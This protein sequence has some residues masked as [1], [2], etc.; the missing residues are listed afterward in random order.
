MSTFVDPTS[1]LVEY[2]EIMS[3][4]FA[5][6]AEPYYDKMVSYCQSK[7]WHQLTLLVLE[8]FAAKNTL[9]VVD[10]KDGAASTS[11]TFLGVYNHI[12]LKVAA[13]LNPLA[14][15]RMA[16]EVA[17]LSLDSQ[18]L[19]SGVAESEAAMA[20]SKKLLQDLLP[21]TEQ[22]ATLYLQSK[23]AL[24]QMKGKTT[25]PEELPKIYSTIKSNATL[26]HQLMMPDTPEAILVHS[27]HYQM[28]MTYFKL[29]GP[30]EAFYEEAIRYLNYYQPDLT[31]LT[32][33]QEQHQLAVD[34]CLA[35]L[36]GDGV[37]NLGQ[38]VTN[39][40]LKCLANT[41]EHWLVDLLSAC[42]MGSVAEF[43]ACVNTKYSTQIAA[44]PALVNMG[45]KMQEKMTLLSL[46][47]MV[48]ERPSSERTLSF[49]DIAA[50]LDIS[51]EQVEWVIMRAFSVNLMQGSMD[52]VDGI[53]HVTW[54]LP[55]VLDATQLSDL[56]TRF[57]E[58][59]TNVSA[60]K[61]YMQQQNPALTA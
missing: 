9:R 60:T 6:L 7:L 15:A 42:S 17:Y 33:Q 39:P 57:G 31:S 36:V 37:Y 30:P 20:T 16:A 19:P 10:A 46:V 59:G 25:P 49:E 13:K 8:F 29:M 61:D 47:Q 2:C 24:L 5:D 48:F 14:L 52:Q 55:R 50:R 53:V 32:A 12:V 27:A 45:T 21:K 56:A 11:N 26:L 58:W 28:S 43:K 35:A 18:V 3:G 22:P 41:P 44:Q 51:M 23:L 54:I 1:S 34:L 40:I 38:V 4:T